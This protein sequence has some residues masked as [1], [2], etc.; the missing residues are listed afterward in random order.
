MILGHQMRAKPWGAKVLAWV[1][2]LGL[3]SSLGLYPVDHRAKRGDDIILVK[4]DGTSVRVPTEGPMANEAAQS[5]ARDIAALDKRAKSGHGESADPQVTE[6]VR[7]LSE[8]LRNDAIDKLDLSYRVAQ[9]TSAPLN[10]ALIEAAKGSANMLSKVVSAP[11]PLN[12][13]VH[14][15]ITTSIQNAVLHYCLR[16]DVKRNACSWKSYVPG[17]AL[18]IGLYVF[19]AESRGN[20]TPKDEEI[21]VLDDPTKHTILPG[22]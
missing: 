13:N 1:S 19:R 3:F 21:L 16:G 4:S 5:V 8:A 7:N 12:L 18:P 6:A 20:D 17:D 2:V 10:T 11:P 14:T 15:E 9:S 22:R